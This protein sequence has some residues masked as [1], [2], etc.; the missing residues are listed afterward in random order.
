MKIPMT[1]INKKLVPTVVIA[2]S[3]PKMY[4][5]V[6]SPMLI[7]VSYDA[8][9]A[10]VRSAEKLRETISIVT[11]KV[12]PTPPPMSI[13]PINNV[14]KVGKMAIVKESQEDQK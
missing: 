7:T 2:V 3:I 10:P 14:R 9:A 8:T 11:G 5:P 6:V 1:D 4:G 12:T 13:K